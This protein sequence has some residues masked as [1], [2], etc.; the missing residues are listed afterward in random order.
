MA[1]S[2]ELTYPP[3]DADP[4]RSRFTGDQRD[5]RTHR[6]LSVEE[7]RELGQLLDQRALTAGGTMAVAEPQEAEAPVGAGWFG[8]IAQEGI[9]TGDKRQIAAGALSWRELPLTLMAQ[10]STPG[11]GG[12][13]DAKIAGRIDT[14]ERSGENIEGAG[15]FDTGE[16]GAETE[17]LVREKILNGISVDLAINEAEVIPDPAIEDP[18]EAYWMGTLNVLDG[19]ILG[20]TIVPFPAFENAQIALVA[21][22]FQHLTELRVEE[23]DGKR[24]KVASFF[25]PFSAQMATPP[26]PAAGDDESDPQDASDD[27]AEAVSDIR[28]AVNGWP[29]LDGQVVVTID[30]ADT[31]ISFP[32]ASA[33]GDEPGEAAL[34]STDLAL[35]AHLRARLLAYKKGQA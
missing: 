4:N 19:T 24:R 20:A 8:A 35:L 18:D 9:P 22:S 30:G 27:A 10:H 14:I 23:I 25:M 34:D 7:A 1:L 16:H 15:V 29:G 28:D 26:P 31:T 12:H 21:G 2:D 5:E 32:P 11:F 6:V 33:S 17:R 13:A 3:G